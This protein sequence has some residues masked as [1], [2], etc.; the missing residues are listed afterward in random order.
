MYAYF[1]SGE[2][3]MMNL[4]KKMIKGAFVLILV[5]ILSCVAIDQYVAINANRFINKENM[6]SANVVLVLGAR[7]TPQKEPSPVL[8]ERL[9][10]A[11][12]MYE[13]GIAKKVIVSGDH[14]SIYYNEVGVMKAYLVENGIPEQDIFMDHAG[15]STYESMVR[16]KEIFGLESL[17]VTTQSYHLKRAVYIG[18]VLGIETFGVSADEGFNLY[19]LRYRYREML[20]RIKDFMYV[21]IVKPDPTYLGDPISIQ[22]DGRITEEMW[23]I[24]GTTTP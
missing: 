10:S 18:R 9:D 4:I 7:V 24:I 1:G 19:V 2:S 22:G 14:D 13:E 11:I 8:A 6:G 15:F 17:I 5:F 12:K 16:A 23:P 3:K 20:A 21:H